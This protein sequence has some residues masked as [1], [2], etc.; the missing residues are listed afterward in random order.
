LHLRSRL[1]F[2]TLQSNQPQPMSITDFTA[3]AD[4]VREINSLRS[5][6]E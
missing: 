4:V 3:S 6:L 2:Q 1:L 5:H